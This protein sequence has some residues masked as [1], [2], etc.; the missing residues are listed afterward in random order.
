M[1]VIMFKVKFKVNIGPCKI[2]YLRDC[3]KRER[4]KERE[5]ERESQKEKSKT[6]PSMQQGVRRYLARRLPQ[7]KH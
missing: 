6:L 7:I 1:F 2:L 3:N 5:R 4:E